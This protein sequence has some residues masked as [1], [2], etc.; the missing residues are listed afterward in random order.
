MTETPK[1]S[2]EPIGEPASLRSA[3]ERAADGKP[4]REFEISLV[5]T[6]GA[7]SQRYRFEFTARGSGALSTRLSDDMAGRQGRSQER[8]DPSE[9]ADLARTILGSG[10]LET[11]A[12]SPR[13]LP[14]T[15]VGILDI[16][17]GRT[18][19]R[20]YFAADSDQAQVQDAQPP[21]A[22]AKVADAIYA[23]SAKRMSRRSVKP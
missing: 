9:V 3:L 17:S 19:F 13:L 4:D 6:G 14:D 11:A 18:H 7:P 21:R 12:D 1:D 23:L 15:L 5:V 10:V 8:L 22:I 2:P 16:S 20:R